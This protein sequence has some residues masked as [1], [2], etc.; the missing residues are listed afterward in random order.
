MSASVDE[1]QRLR[2]PPRITLFMVGGPIV[3][4]AAVPGVVVLAALTSWW[5]LFALPPLMM[6]LCGLIMMTAM[7]GPSRCS[8]SA[9]AARNVTLRPC[10]RSIARAATPCGL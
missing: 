4:A 6:T 5:V 1:A 7:R 9:A 8:G 2:Y 3:G 10:P